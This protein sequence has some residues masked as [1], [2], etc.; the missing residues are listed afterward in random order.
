MFSKWLDDAESIL[1]SID[2]SVIAGVVGMNETGVNNN[3]RAINVLF[4]GDP[5]ENWGWGNPIQKSEIVQTLDE[6]LI[7]IPKSIFNDLKFDEI[8][9]QKWDLYAV[10]YCLNMKK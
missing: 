9:C 8:T 4:H 10:E 5:P 2:D 1:K 7:I 6:C 3:E